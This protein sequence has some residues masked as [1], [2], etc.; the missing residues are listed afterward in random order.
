MADVFI[1]YSRTDKD[2]VRRLHDG[3]AKHN[4]D[5]WVDWEDIPLTA[6]WL[7]EIH[8]GIDAAEN[9]VFVISPESVASAVCREELGHAL[10]SNKRLI[11]I[12]YRAVPDAEVPEAL[13]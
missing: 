9:F 13:A 10:A 12:F 3:L 1:S 6:E 8:A 7:K 11:P 2:F 5:T 4:R